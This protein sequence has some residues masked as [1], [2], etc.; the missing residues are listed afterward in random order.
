MLGYLM[1]ELS[2]SKVLVLS[3]ALILVSLMDLLGLSLFIPI[4]DSLQGNEGSKHLVSQYFSNALHFLGIEPS[5]T[6]F[7]GLLS[8]LFIVK[9]LIALWARLMS[10]SM[11][12]G[13][14]H[15]LRT[16]LLHGYLSSSLG[17][18]NQQRQGTLLSVLNE[19]TIR[20]AG[21]FFIL[22]QVL[23][24]WLTALV[25]GIF[26]FMIS[27]ELTI[28]ALAL[29]ALMFPFIKSIGRLAHDY[30][31]KNIRALEEAQ[32][33]ALESLQA[34]KLVN[35]MSW[36]GSRLE[37][38]QPV[39]LRVKESWQWTAFWSNSVGIIVQPISVIVLSVLIVLSINMD[40]TFAVL[41]AFIL[42]FLRF[43]PTIQ[44]AL[45]MGADLKASLPSVKRV[46]EFLDKTEQAVEPSGDRPFH[47]LEEGIELDSVSFGYNDS[48]DAEILSN[49]SV[50]IPRG[51]TVAMVGASGSGKTTVADLILGLNRPTNGRVLID[52][53]DLS[54]ID[55][56]QL[57]EKVA[58]IP[59]EPIL[60][61][62]SIRNNLLM[63]LDREVDAH[64]MQSVCIQAGAWDFIKERT[65]GLDTVIGDRG[66]QLSGGQRQRLALARALLRRPQLMILDEA[67]SALDHDSEHWI[68]QTL[69]ELRSSRKFTIFIIAHRFTTIQHADLI[70][71]L[72]NKRISLLGDWS[73]AKEHLHK[74]VAT[75]DLK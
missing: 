61:H 52:G 46:K 56:R 66:T 4:L 59:Q 55:L 15:S 63:G 70:Y 11:S 32:H 31:E 2:A 45:T 20:A 6:W 40:F 75:L 42:A 54:R 67:T 10:V 23:L 49:A 47:G 26:V 7:L 18:I 36:G 72:E 44:S 33:F 71:Q 17:F 39:S 68:Q 29:G 57:R 53:E 62:D 22:V 38:Y 64:E 60:F 27:W 25:Y 3:V 16:R 48:P 50:L 74:K 69:E 73:Q 21:A 12:S 35:A 24:L 14:Q 41:G 30:A 28:V 37:S 19:H 58:Y 8:G 5:L 9:T 13:L 51:N 65:L 43:L 34:K 1:D